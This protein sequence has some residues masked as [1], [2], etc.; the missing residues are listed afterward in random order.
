MWNENDK[1]WEYEYDNEGKIAIGRDKECK[2]WEEIG[3]ED[4]KIGNEM[5]IKGDDNTTF[6]QSYY[7][8]D[9]NL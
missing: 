9:Y 2:I 7:Y 6:K 4:G 3:E 5:S 1:D 8:H